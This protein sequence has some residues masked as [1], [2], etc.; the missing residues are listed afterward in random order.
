LDEIDLSMNLSIQTKSLTMSHPTKFFH[1]HQF[2]QFKKSFL[3]IPGLPFSEILSNTLLAGIWQHGGRERIF[4]PLVVLKAFLVQVL[5]ADGSCKQAVARVLTER[6]QQ[7][8][9]PN[10]GQIP[11]PIARRGNDYRWLP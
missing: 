4:T 9:A 1:F 5:S 8:R 10:T 6:L 2:Q 3:Q 7:G 11:V